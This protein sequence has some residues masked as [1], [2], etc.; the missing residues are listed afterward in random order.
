MRLRVA[1]ARRRFRSPRAER[2]QREAMFRK[3]RDVRAERTRRALHQACTTPR[4]P[5]P[6]SSR[7]APAERCAGTEATPTKALSV[8]P[9]RHPAGLHDV[10]VARP[11]VNE[12]CK[13]QKHC[14]YCGEFN[15]TV[16]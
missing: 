6:C 14:P 15:G 16:K 12:L 9:A 7:A 5:P 8:V 2:T 11:Q 10:L 4:K 13:R 3:V 1:A